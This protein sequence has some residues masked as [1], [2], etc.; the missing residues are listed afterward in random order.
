[1]EVLKEE[2]ERANHENTPEWKVRKIFEI[3]LSGEELKIGSH[4]FLMGKK[5]GES[6]APVL[7]LVLYNDK[8]GE[9]VIQP[10]MSLN[11]FIELALENLTHEQL[12]EKL[13]QVGF[14]KHKKDQ[15]GE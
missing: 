7:L 6:R 12:L 13:A 15:R 2:V 8:K 11:D 3:L 14:Q 1:M 4:R 10:D 9:I 5:D